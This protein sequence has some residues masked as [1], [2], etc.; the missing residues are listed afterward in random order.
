M[1]T[2]K[3]NK[4]INLDLNDLKKV[5]REA[6][7]EINQEKRKSQDERVFYLSKKDLC[8]RHNLTISAVTTIIKQSD[9]R[10][11]ALK[12]GDSVNSV[13]KFS[14]QAFKQELLRCEMEI[15]ESNN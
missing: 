3:N 6:I 13:Q 11:R 15:T 5:V 14:K 1:T 12:I 10:V 4:N 2:A 7:I 8:K 9:G